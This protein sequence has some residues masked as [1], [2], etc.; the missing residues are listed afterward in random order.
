VHGQ[1][2]QWCKINTSLK[3]IMFE[4][5]DITTIDIESINNC[6]AK[7]PLCLRGQN[8]RT[9]DVLDWDKVVSSTS[10]EL[11]SIVKSINFNGNTGDNLM[12]PKIFEIIDWCVKHSSASISIHT[13]GSLRSPDW[14][15]KFGL[16]LSQPQ[17]KVVFGIDGL[18]DTHSIYRVGTDYHKIIENAKAFIKG[19]GRAEWQFI[20]FE[21]NAHQIEQAQQ[22][23]NDLGFSRF[24]VLYQDR[25]EQESN[26]LVQ[27][28]NQDLTTINAEV[29]F[30]SSSNSLTKRVAESDYNIK[31]RSQQI[32]WI[33]IYA[34]GT[35][36][37]CCWLMGWHQAQHQ[38]QSLLINHHFK[39]ILGID[40]DQINLYNNNLQDIIN[41]DLWQKRYP[42]SFVNRPN[43]VCLQQCS[44]TKQ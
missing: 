37:P 22:L 31:C 23:A 28:Y 8:M 21:H 4:L 38:T 10:L 25:F 1:L 6:N 2:W 20:L 18:A 11:W 43:P 5:T 35:V 14:W 40:F 26:L 15:E 44:G 29:R 30:N 17:N 13:N 36:W 19:G 9:N 33:S 7:C 42:A 12:H 39:K 3:S 24:F 41:S 34:D 32:G 16:L 27:R